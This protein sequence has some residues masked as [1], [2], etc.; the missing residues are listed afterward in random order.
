M[1]TKFSNG[2][3]VLLTYMKLHEI[4]VTEGNYDEYVLAHMEQNKQQFDELFELSEAIRKV[5][6]LQGNMGF[7]ET[8]RSLHLYLK[9]VQLMGR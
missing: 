4:I 9:Q 7:S 1:R 5:F 6:G 3:R 2:E 8:I